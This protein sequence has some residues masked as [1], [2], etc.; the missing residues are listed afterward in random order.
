MYISIRNQFCS[1]IILNHCLCSAQNSLSGDRANDFSS[2]LWCKF[3]HI[4]VVYFT[5]GNLHPKYRSSLKGILLLNVT[6]YSQIQR[7]GIDAVLE[8]IFK[9]VKQLEEVY[10]LVYINY[11]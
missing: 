1:C 10:T 8:P 2:L 4:G 7:Y 5:L 6:Y 3:V 11:Y 9:D